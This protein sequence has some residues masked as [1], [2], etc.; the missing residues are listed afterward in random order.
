MVASSIEDLRGRLPCDGVL[1]HIAQIFPGEGFSKVCGNLPLLP[2]RLLRHAGPAHHVQNQP[3]HVQ[4][5]R[6]KQ[7]P[8]WCLILKGQH[9]EIGPDAVGQESDV[10]ILPAGL[11]V[12]GR[13][14]G[15]RLPGK[16]PPGSLPPT[17]RNRGRRPGSGLPPRRCRPCRGHIKLRVSNLFTSALSLWAVCG[18]TVHPFLHLGKEPGQVEPVRRRVVDVHG[19]RHDQ[20]AVL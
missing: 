4:H 19:Q 15:R 18:H 20:P 6:H 9:G 10:L 12:G 13:D 8:V 14:L 17:H 5:R 1:L 11:V 2:Q 16:L 7:R 3:L